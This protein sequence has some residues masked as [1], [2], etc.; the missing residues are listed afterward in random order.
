MTAS[1]TPLAA[2]APWHFWLVVVIAVLWNGFGLYDLVMSLTRGDAYF[3][4]MGMTE[5]QIAY[6]HAMPPWTY[7]TWAL[8][9]GGSVAGTVLLLLRSRFALHAFVASLIGLLL[10]LAYVYLMSDGA[11]AMGEMG[12]VMN[13]VITAGCLFFIWYAWL[14]TKRGLLR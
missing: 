9:V 14:M 8:G 1:T 11:Q 12:G 7:A 3:R 5:D 13:V 10:N 6:F 2:R 4:A